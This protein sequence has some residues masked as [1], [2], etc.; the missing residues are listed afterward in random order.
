MCGPVG[1][2]AY[3]V[4]HIGDFRAVFDYFFPGLMAGQGLDDFI[5]GQLDAVNPG[6]A[7]TD[8]AG[9]GTQMALIT[10]GALQPYSRSSE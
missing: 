10:S 4:D 3:Q 6:Q 5:V 1:D 7:L 8:R 9:H 2:F